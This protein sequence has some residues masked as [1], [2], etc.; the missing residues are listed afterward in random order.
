[1]RLLKSIKLDVMTSLAS[2]MRV[3]GFALTVILTMAVTLASLA[4][5]LNIN[6]LVLAKPLPYPNAD[7]IVVTSQ[8]ET[9]NGETQYGFQILP[10]QFHIYRDKT[11]IE[12]MTIM[13]LN[14][15]RLRE[16]PG[17]PYLDGLRVTPEY[18]EMVNMPIELGRAFNADEGAQN[19]QK[20]MVLSHA[21]WQKHF[22][23]DPDIIGQTV[24]LGSLRYKIIGVAAEDFIAPELFGSFP[25]QAWFS[26]PEALSITSGWGSITSSLTGIAKLKDGVTVEQDNQVLGEQINALYQAQE[27]VAPNTSIGLKLVSLKE[28]IIGE[29]R[30]TALL[31]LV[32]VMTL[33]F[34]AISNITNLFLSRAAQKQRVIAIQAALGAKPK[35]LFISLF[36]EACVLLLTA[37]FIGL[38]IAGW[39]LILLENDLQ[40]MFTRL[41]NL[42]LDG[43]TI[44]TSVF[45]SILIS[46]LLAFVAM[47]QIN[48]HQLTDTLHASG[49]GTGAQISSITRNL[50]V[51][52]QVTFA[53]MLLLGATAI[54]KP[55]ANRLLQET[56][57][58]SHNLHHLSVDR[59]NFDGDVFA[60]SLGPGP[61]FHHMGP[62]LPAD[63]YQ[64]RPRAHGRVADLEI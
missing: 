34:I 10:T 7:K 56:G 58:D 22:A 32:G 23:G 30:T 45:V 8:S 17:A 12:T 39:V 18:F 61:R 33:L 59:G 51:A 55:V 64:E 5:V 53:T 52:M 4:V 35:H 29:G 48:Y 41:Q 9:I 40:Y 63:R 24:Q 62:T 46:T 14:G 21:S 38:I 1:M 42:S 11:Y 54:L 37:C 26:F 19:E 36:S 28:S 49:K 16:L 25:I 44:L 47:R 15:E 6:Y 43:V 31:L 20:V 50:L 2:L 27:N 60:L 13:S 57:F 3:P